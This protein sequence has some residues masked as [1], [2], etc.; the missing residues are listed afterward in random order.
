M[1]LLLYGAQSD[2]DTTQSRQRGLADAR[3]RRSGFSA[4]RR[5]QNAAPERLA[6]SFIDGQSTCT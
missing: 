2:R 4:K 1:D 5:A 3:V 6:G